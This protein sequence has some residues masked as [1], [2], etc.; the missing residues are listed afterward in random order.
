VKFITIL[1][2]ALILLTSCGKK[3]FVKER[4]EKPLFEYK[5]FEHGL[6]PKSITLKIYKDGYVIFL[7]KDEYSGAEKKKAEYLPGSDVEGLLN[8]FI[9]EDFL[10]VKPLSLPA[11]YGGILISITFNHKGNSKTIK[12][13]KGTK[14]PFSVEKCWDGLD[15]IL[16]QFSM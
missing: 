3:E 6:N 14:I 12:F 4:A 9:E 2:A 15:K 8:L 5:E 13:L 16:S 10:N 7:S 1:F 11:I